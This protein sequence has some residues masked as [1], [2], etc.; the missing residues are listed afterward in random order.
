MFC[1]ERDCS[2]RGFFPYF[3]CALKRGYGLEG[4]LEIAR[5]TGMEASGKFNPPYCPSENCE[6]NDP[7]RVKK[8][9][10][11]VKCGLA[12]RKLSNSVQVFK[13][14]RCCRKFNANYFSLNYRF[15]REDSLNFRIFTAITH[16]RSFRSIARELSV[17]ECLVRGRVARLYRVGLLHHF[18]FL[19]KV[20]I[21]EPVAYD[22]L[23]CFARSQYEPNNINQAIGVDSLFCYT[24]NFAPMNRKGRM[25]DRQK[26]Y[27]KKLEV[28]EGRFNP[29]AIRVSTHQLF[30]DLL[31]RKDPR[32][33]KLVL[34]TDEHFQYRRAIKRDLSPAQRKAIEHKTVSS[35]D[36][37]NYKNILFPVNH[38]DLL[39]RRYV[40][41]FSRETICFSKKHTTMLGVYVLFMCSK[42]YM[43]PC[44][45]KK[46]KRDVTAHTHS[47]AMKLG[48]VDNLMEFKDFFEEPLQ[49]KNLHRHKANMP[50]SWQ[51]LLDGE[52]EFKRERKYCA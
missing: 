11:W 25:S 26:N 36:C 46:H 19:E 21:N 5:V 45:V 50:A 14:K 44:F 38:M 28:L 33:E 16:N 2:E 7:D 15:H 22:G 8:T 6:F 34:H 42:N 52:V 29:R 12:K 18:D 37:R 10:F 30:T 17:S 49:K 3:N 47:P 23:E 43:R 40:A 9:R 20:L 41:A 1:K 39:I 32:L 31:D 35:K 51:L 48:L 4:G 24:F 13:C 27:L